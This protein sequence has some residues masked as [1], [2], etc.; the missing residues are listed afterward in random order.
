[1]TGPSGLGDAGSVLPLPALPSPIAL[2]TPSTLPAPVALPAPVVPTA[3]EPRPQPLP[4]QPPGAAVA[5][6][7]GHCADGYRTQGHP[8]T[9]ERVAGPTTVIPFGPRSAHPLHPFPGQAAT[10]GISRA[11]H[12]HSAAPQTPAPQTPVPQAPGGD[13]DGA[14]GTRSTADSGEPIH[15]DLHAVTSGGRAPLPRVRSTVTSLAAAG[16]RD[17]R[18][19]VPVY[20]G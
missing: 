13:P 18:E 12:R 11:V 19:D 15:G 3:S 1:M 14:V 9:A 4:Q 17:V 2:P 16:I 7:A 6:P 10:H 8:R 20:P 5:A